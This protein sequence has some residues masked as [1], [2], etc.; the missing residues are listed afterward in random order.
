M[1][2]PTLTDRLSQVIRDVP[3]FPSA[4]IL[5]KD[6][7]PVLADPA[8]MR[9][10]LSSMAE[11]V[12]GAGITHVVAVES[13][14]FLFGMPLALELG[15][16]FA[17]A[18]KPGKLPWHTVREAYTLEYRSDVLEMHEDALTLGMPGAG[19]PRVLVVDD[20]LATGGTAAATCR[21]VERLGGEVVAVSVLVEL[22]FLDG[23]S[24]LPGRRVVPVVRY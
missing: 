16:A 23:R 20:V 7:T 15:V 14:G 11:P 21:L 5:F 17:P 10:T 9:E 13:R 1:T 8:L 12:V 24:R 6:I 19:R 2:T 4:G 22:G 18:R 3:D